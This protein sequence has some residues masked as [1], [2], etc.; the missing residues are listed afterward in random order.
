MHTHSVK[1]GGEKNPALTSAADRE[2]LAKQLAD[3]ERRY[4]VKPR[5]R[6]TRDSLAG[7]C[8]NMQTAAAH[9]TSA[10]VDPFDDSQSMLATVL[11]IDALVRAWASQK[12][13]GALVPP[14]ADYAET[15]SELVERWRIT[16]RRELEASD[17][18]SDPLLERLSA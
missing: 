11:W 13:R 18:E 2:S 9:A 10:G 8:R 16:S 15:R 7:A 5:D 12:S 4:R 3:L 14:P 1:S 17:R 6:A